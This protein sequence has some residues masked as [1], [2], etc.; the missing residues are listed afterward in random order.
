MDNGI[1]VRDVA[2]SF[3]GSQE[4]LSVYGQNSSNSDFLGRLY[5]NV[6]GRA[7]EA[8]GLVY[9]QGQLEKGVSRASV[10]ACRKHCWDIDR[11]KRRH[12]VLKSL[13]AVEFKL[14]IGGCNGNGSRHSEGLYRV[15]QPACR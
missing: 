9:W 14:A 2:Q 6:L 8:D 4:F 1:S 5:M 7:R 11:N 12:L 3:V 13:V 10:R 15:F